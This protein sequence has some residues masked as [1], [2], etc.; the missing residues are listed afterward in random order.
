MDILKM[1]NTNKKLLSI[2]LLISMFLTV[3]VFT[4][5]VSAQQTSISIDTIKNWF[6]QYDQIRHA[7]QMTPTERQ[8]ADQILGKGL[9]LFMPGEEKLVAQKLLMDLVKRYDIACHQL[10]DLAVIPATEALHRGYYQYFIDAHHLF[11]DYLKLQDDLLAVDPANGQPLASGLID[12]KQALEQ[13]DQ[14]NKIL[15]QQLRTQYGIA[16]YQY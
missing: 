6:S 15:D 4:E 1:F 10:S 8:Q 9:A 12:R 13:L 16:P 7:A 11:S 2:C 5:T 3:F 14:N